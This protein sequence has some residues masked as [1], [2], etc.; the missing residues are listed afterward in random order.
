MALY[1][2]DCI[3][4]LDCIEDVDCIIADLPYFKIVKNDF[5]NQW[6]SDAEYLEWV[7]S[8]LSKAV[9]RLKPNGACILFASRQMQWRICSILDR[10]GLQEQRMIVWARKRGFNSTRGHALS[11]GYEPVLYWTKGSAGTFNQIKI[12]PRTNRPE[13]VTGILKNGV[14]LSDVWTDIPALP[15]NAKERVAHPT[16]KPVRLMER[17]VEMFTNSD[18]L[19]LDFCMGS[20]S[21][22][23]ACM[24]LGRRFIGIEKDAEYF[25]LAKTRI[26]RAAIMNGGS[27]HV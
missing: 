3:N 21:T 18:D 7:E 26:E 20:G 27:V 4:T 13:Y 2:A 6:K 22:G 10:L 23:V 17:I 19:V 8:V 25:N 24:N 15:H 5:D 16:Q 11:S 9:K 12:K 1:N 14:S